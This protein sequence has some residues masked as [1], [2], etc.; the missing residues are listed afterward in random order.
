MTTKKPCFK[1]YFKK[2][3]IKSIICSK[4]N[5]YP[6]NNSKTL[7]NQKLKKSKK[8]NKKHKKKKRENK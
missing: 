3:M 7:L 8:I 1:A 2:I 4:M 5:N 6:K